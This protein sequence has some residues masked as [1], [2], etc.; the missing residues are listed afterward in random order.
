MEFRP[1]LDL[2]RHD[3]VLEAEWNIGVMS[4][5]DLLA[6]GFTIE[7]Y[8]ALDTVE[9]RR[10][11][12]DAFSDRQWKFFSFGPSLWHEYPTPPAPRLNHHLLHS[13]PLCQFLH[14]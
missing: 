1:A 7:R 14:R 3:R 8:H 12:V 11:V 13:S 2:S 9:R 5:D 6:R 4:V 10:S